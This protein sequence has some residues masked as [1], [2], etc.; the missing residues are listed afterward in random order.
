MHLSAP[1]HDALIIGAGFFGLEIALELRR[2]GFKRVLVVE[3][4]DRIMR[5]ASY[6]NQARVHNGYHY[7]RSPMTADRSHANFERFVVDYADA[8]HTGMDSVYAIARGSRISASQFETFCHMLDVP[9]RPAPR[10]IA[11]LF[12]D[13]LIEAAYVTREVTFDTDRIAIRLQAELDG[14]GVEVRLGTT[15]RILG[16]DPDQVDV[17][18]AGSVHRARYVFNCTYSDIEFAGVSLRAGIKKELTEMVLMEPPRELRDVGVT[19]MD[20][21]FFSCM[22]FPSLGLHSLSHVT[23][24][25]HESYSGTTRETLVPTKSNR[26]AMI[27]DSQRYMPSLGRAR[28]VGSMFEVK[29][30]LIR[31]EK[32][33]GRPILIER[34][35]HLPNVMSVLGAKIDNIYEVRDFLR[36]QNWRL[37]W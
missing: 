34:A 17:A 29:A 33:D 18:V 31:N 27:R 4:E 25:P 12:D 19:V 36:A 13:A 30:I 21:P 24:T 1:R 11:D 2:L 22:P 35:E 9:C 28:V 37:S 6:V 8:V 10:A 14:A 7:P 3:R 23:Y 16:G 32:D 26:V 5:R 15:A 20:G